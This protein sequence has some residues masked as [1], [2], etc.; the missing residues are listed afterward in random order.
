VLVQPKVIKTGTYTAAKCKAKHADTR[1]YLHNME[2][3]ITVRQLSIR[4]AFLYLTL[5]Q[6]IF[7]KQYS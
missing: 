4:Y 5:C 1:K 3:A 7:P 6:V 2:G